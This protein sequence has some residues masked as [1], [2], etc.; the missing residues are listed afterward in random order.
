MIVYEQE[1]YDE[2]KDYFDLTSING[3]YDSLF[4]RIHK[5]PNAQNPI[6]T[7]TP[8][9]LVKYFT[10]IFR[11]E[12]QNLKKYL[13]QS[14]KSYFNPPGLRLFLYHSYFDH[15]RRKKCITYRTP[16][17]IFNSTNVDFC[18]WFWDPKD[19][20]K[21]KSIVR[22]YEYYAIPERIFQSD[23]LVHISADL[24]NPPP[25]R[26]QYISVKYLIQLKG[27]RKDFKKIDP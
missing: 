12:R 25:E 2:N 13:G 7:N 15:F 20:T 10:R 24:E 26:S 22:I 5:Q 4:D 19:N 16:Y 11:P 6:S 1:N 9:E 27:R 21:W 23:F 3:D 8:E 18:L 14:N 17:R